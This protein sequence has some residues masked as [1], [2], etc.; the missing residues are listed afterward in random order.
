[1]WIVAQM[2]KVVTTLVAA[3][4]IVVVAVLSGP[5]DQ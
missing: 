1:M 5:C 2:L 4:L 3:G